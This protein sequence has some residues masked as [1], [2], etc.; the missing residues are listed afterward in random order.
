MVHRVKYKRVH[1]GATLAKDN[2][3]CQNSLTFEHDL[4]F[5][6]FFRTLDEMAI[7]INSTKLWTFLNQIL[8]KI[9][10]DVSLVDEV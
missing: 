10:D 8:K 1:N 7:G 4:T 2:R 3:M 6:T 5:K 9:Y